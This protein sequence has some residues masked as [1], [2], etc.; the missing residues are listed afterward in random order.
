VKT[1]EYFG[2]IYP[3][4][5]IVCPR[6]DGEGTHTN[7]SIDGNGLTQSDIDEAMHDDPEFLDNYF[8]GVYDV[9]CHEC[10]G[11]RVILAVDYD[12]MT[13][14]QEAQYNSDLDEERSWEAEHQAELRAGC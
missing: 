3:A 9:M 6:C 14:E 1:L 8:G 10:D 12:A 5:N 4:K 7:P 11:K 13:E 2:N